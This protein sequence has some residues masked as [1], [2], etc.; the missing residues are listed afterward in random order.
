MIVVVAA[1]GP[2]SYFSTMA[3]VVDCHSII[4]I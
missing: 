4:P 1:G 3:L 2:F